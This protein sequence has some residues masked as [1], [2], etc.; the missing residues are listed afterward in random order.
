MYPEFV[1]VT[2]QMSMM[3]PIYV[4][5]EQLGAATELWG[6]TLW[7][8]LDVNVLSEGIDA[9]LGRARKLTKTIRALP[10]S[11]L[12]AYLLTHCGFLTI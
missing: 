12:L 9:L 8:D 4:I 7:R 1:T 5:F 2:Q 3:E 11:G 6:E 10:V